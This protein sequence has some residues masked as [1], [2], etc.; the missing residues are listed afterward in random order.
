MLFDWDDAKAERNRQKHGVT[1]DE[2]TT[3]FGDLFAYTRPDVWHSGGEDRD[4]TLGQSDRGR[5]LAV[6]TT[7]RRESGQRV[8]RIITARRATS[9]E[10]NSYAD[11]VRQQTRGTGGDA[12][13]GRRRP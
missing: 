7:E 3:V 8:V 11:Y 1:F 6:V 13:R 5:V 4:I 2:A 12:D 10:V 9:Q